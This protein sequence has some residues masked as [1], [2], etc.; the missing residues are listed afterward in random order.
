MNRIFAKPL[1]H[2]VAI[3]LIGLAYAVREKIS[4]SEQG[5]GR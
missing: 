2:I 5:A 4:V 1:P 3:I